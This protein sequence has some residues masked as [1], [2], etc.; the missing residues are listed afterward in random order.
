MG[1]ARHNL[2]SLSRIREYAFGPRGSPPGTGDGLVGG[3]RTYLALGLDLLGM[4]V[5]RF[6]TRHHRQK[7]RYL[8]VD[9]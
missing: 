5:H 9:M 4:T 1:R 3:G 7:K 6:A 2:R 8:E